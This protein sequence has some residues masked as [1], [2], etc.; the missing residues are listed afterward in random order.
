EVP[1]VLYGAGSAG[2][3]LYPI[4][5][6]HGINPACFCDSNASRAGQMHCGLPVISLSELSEK[7]KKSLIIITIGAHREELKQHLVAMGFDQRRVRAISNQE[8]LCYYTHL[9]QWYWPEKDLPQYEN[10][11]SRVYDLLSDQKSRDLFLTRTALLFRGGDYQSFLNFLLD[12]SDV[13]YAEG[14][15]F[16]AQPQPTTYIVDTYFQFNNDIIHLNNL[17]VLIDGG[18]FT[19]DSAQEF[20]KACTKRNLTY[21]KIIC[22]E[23]D[24]MTFSELEKNT[25]QYS[26]IVLRPFGLWSHPDTVRFVD[27]NVLKNG[28][29]RIV[30]EN[31]ND[32][33]HLCSASSITEIR[34]TSIDE[35]ISDEPITLIKM[36]VEGAEIEALHGATK[37]IRKCRPKLIISAYH[38]RTD[39]FEVPLLVHDIVPDYK[40]Y[41]RHFSRDFG[42]TM[43]IAIP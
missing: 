37:T 7:H 4:L 13:K 41:F 5:K 6:S 40:L 20:I 15:T 43:L 19:G 42:D 29:A 35:D 31:G 23:P 17:E 9:A 2:K 25:A 1:V 11:L 22:F 33:S 3:E 28:G 27:S 39:I 8:A 30:S 21:K 32:T 10:Q 12:Y 38:K 26:N 34:T 24:P 18:A 36:D 16:Q 14:S